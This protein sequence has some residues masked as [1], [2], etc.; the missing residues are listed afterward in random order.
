MF[1]MFDATI[2]PLLRAL[3]NLSHILKKGEAHADARNIEHSVLL[4]ARLFPDMYPLIRQVQIATDMSKGAAARL[5]GLDVPS[6]E[7][8]ETTF[9][10]L[11]ARLTKTIAFIETVKPE[12]LVGSEAR[13]VTIT[14]R[15]ANLTFTGQDYLLKWVN[16]NVY[17]HVTTAYNI[18]R[19]NGVELGKP[20]FLRGKE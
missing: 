10:D 12:Q 7:D 13:E 6:Y 15:K 1:T 19:H 5:A 2:P 16:P 9:A 11:Q 4:N 3:N 8:N 17:F 18:L 14:V 20:D